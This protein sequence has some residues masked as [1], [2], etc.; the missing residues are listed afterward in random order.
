MRYSSQILWKRLC[1]S[2]L[3]GI[4]VLDFK[5]VF[6]DAEF[7]GNHAY[8]IQPALRGRG[9]DPQRGRDSALFT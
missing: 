9:G 7:L 5:R 2:G 4:K 1:A 8:R 6:R 3:I